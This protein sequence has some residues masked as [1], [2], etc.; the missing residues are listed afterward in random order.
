M[1]FSERNGYTKIREMFQREELDETTRILLGNAY[2]GTFLNGLYEHTAG[3][4][5]NK[6][7]WSTFFKE[8]LNK[9]PPVEF[10]RFLFNWH[11]SHAKWHKLLSFV[12]FVLVHGE[13]LTHSPCTVYR[14]R[15]NEAFRSE[16]AAYVIIQ[17][18]IV[19]I[20]SEE[21]IKE[22]EKAVGQGGTVKDHMV[23]ALEHFADRENPNYSSSIGESLKAVEALA[24]KIVGN[25]KLTLGQALGAMKKLDGFPSHT[26][27]LEGYSKIYGYA[28]DGGI[29]HAKKDGQKEE[30]DIEDARYMLVSCSTFINYLVVK[31]DKAGIE[32]DIS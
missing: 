2:Q 5:M 26:S 20:T 7:I 13:K 18:R 30:I 22:I 17:N 24:R 6:L 11:V 29:R 12:E 15:C 1:L 21:E 32:L 31:A 27:L 9:Y 23:K 28:S 10:D 16:R 19:E 25:E 8:P 3:Y 4:Q 14:S